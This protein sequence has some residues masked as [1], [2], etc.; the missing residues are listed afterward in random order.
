MNG[1]VPLSHI[2]YKSITKNR[3]V[4]LNVYHIILCGLGGQGLSACF[5]PML[6][7]NLPVIRGKDFLHEYECI[8][9]QSCSNTQVD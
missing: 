9:A 4:V 3:I 5:C 7:F 1:N 8:Q 2:T 6:G